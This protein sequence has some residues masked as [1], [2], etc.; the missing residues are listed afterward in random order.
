MFAQ[1][2]AIDNNRVVIGGAREIVNGFSEGLVF[3]FDAITGMKL[4]TLRP[5]GGGIDENFGSSVAI[6]GNRITV[7]ADSAPKGDR[8]E[9]GA[10]YLYDAIT[11]AFLERIVANYDPVG[12]NFGSSVAIDGNHVIVGAEGFGGLNDN[13]NRIATAGNAFI[14]DISNAGDNTNVH[15]PSA[16]LLIFPFLF[17]PRKH[18]RGKHFAHNFDHWRLSLKP[19]IKMLPI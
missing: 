6:N 12:T 1:S 8:H 5:V 7:G 4:H 16:L 13:I 17:F 15:S 3:V 2:V 9:R 18:V 10:A 11:G 19:S 14:Y